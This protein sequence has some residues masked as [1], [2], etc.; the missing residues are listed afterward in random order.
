[1][2]YQEFLRHI[3]QKYSGS[4]KLGLD[5]MQ[6]VLAD[7]GDPQDRLH[8]FHVA[9]T[10]GKGSVCAVLES[11]ALHHGLSV[12][13]NTSPHL[14][15]YCERFRI[16]GKDTDFQGILDLYHRFERTFDRWDA[17]FFEITTAIAFQMF[18]EASVHTAI[19]EVGVGGR[20][21][22]TNLF[23]PDITAITSIGLDH[24][25]TLGGTVELI[26][27]EKAGIIKPSIPLILGR[28]DESPRQVILDIAAARNAPVLLIGRD[29]I[30]DNVAAGRNGIR[31]DYR[32]GD[33]RIRNIQSNLSGLHQANNLAVAITAFIIYAR[34]H[35][36]PLSIAKLRS[37]LK[38]IN[39]KG[40]MQIVQRHPTLIID[41]A[42]NVQGVTSLM[43]SLIQRYPR[44]KFV[45]IISI[46][47]DKDYKTM[48]RLLCQHAKAV[49]IAQNGSDRAV[50]AAIQVKQA[51]RYLS[52]VH[53]AP[54]VAEALALALEKSS[55]RDVIVAGGSLYT[56][57]EILECYN[58]PL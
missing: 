28:I 55:P 9:G 13:L 21:D 3:Y 14:I 38:S 7:M 44:R 27:A 23:V 5:R 46:L 16:N 30:V 24:V 1:M 57:G 12:G 49:Y 56:V 32:L 22:A 26:A 25:K 48:I 4:V 42:H 17:T 20:L 36:I 40:R 31:F 51:R 54:T 43:Q 11:I 19:I 52:N 34:L 33:L 18:L 58:E 29:F 39:W 41:G 8:G 45:M 35:A 37:A 6:N 10:N 53:S 15:N 47:A 50:S 2:Q